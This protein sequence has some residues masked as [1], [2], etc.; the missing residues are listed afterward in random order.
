ML[1][2]LHTIYNII[3]YPTFFSVR[4]VGQAYPIHFFY[5]STFIESEVSDS[6]LP[7]TEAKTQPA[8]VVR[9]VVVDEA[10]VANT[11]RIV[12]TAQA[13]RAKPPI[14]GR[15]SFIIYYSVSITACSIR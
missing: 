13:R 8:A 7:D 12:R 10:D 3:H 15:T 6:S 2:S 4:W 14:A 5:F 1:A 11:A 9:I